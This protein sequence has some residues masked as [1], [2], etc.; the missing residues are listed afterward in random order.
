MQNIQRD[1]LKPVLNKVGEILVELKEIK[2]VNAN[3]R[4]IC[5]S[6]HPTVGEMPNKDEHAESKCSDYSV[7]EPKRLLHENAQQEE[8]EMLI[9]ETER[10]LNIDNQTS[11][12]TD[13]NTERQFFSDRHRNVCD[14][15]TLIVRNPQGFRSNSLQTRGKLSPSATVAVKP[16]PKSATHLNRGKELSLYI[17]F[18]DR[19]YRRLFLF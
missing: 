8:P 18:V 2:T 11:G 16:R 13:G 5:V 19:F 3:K 4:F 14:N 17:L 12:G 10:P 9:A 6:C 15:V 7:T 1:I